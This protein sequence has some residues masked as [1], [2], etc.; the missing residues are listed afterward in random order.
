MPSPDFP[1][2]LD[3]VGTYSVDH[4]VRLRTIPRTT[5]TGAIV[6][7]LGRAGPTFGTAIGLSASKPGALPTQFISKHQPEHEILLVGELREV[8]G[9]KALKHLEALAPPEEYVHESSAGLGHYEVVTGALKPIL[10]Q[11]KLIGRSGVESERTHSPVDFVD[12]MLNELHDGFQPSSFFSVAVQASMRSSVLSDSLS[13]SKG[14]PRNT[15][16]S[17]A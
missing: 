17:T 4:R 14:K 12:E 3:A 2:S 6:K 7:G 10:K 13:S 8:Q 11:R 5:C 9:R 1:F 16:P 15:S